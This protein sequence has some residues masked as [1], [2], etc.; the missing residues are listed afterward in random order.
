MAEH[1]FQVPMLN[2][3]LPL[4][5]LCFGARFLQESRI[6]TE[7]FIS[8]YRVIVRVSVVLKRTVVG[9]LFLP[10]FLKF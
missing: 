8:S 7:V 4:N 10:N 5:Y 9:D 6:I 2:S 1:S 3:S